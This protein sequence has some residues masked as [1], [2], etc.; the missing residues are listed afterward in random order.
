M[1]KKADNSGAFQALKAALRQKQPHHL[2]IFHGEEDYLRTYYLGALK[3]LLID[4]PAADFNLHRFDARTMDP[5]AFSDAMDAIPVMSEASFIQVDDVDLYQMDAADREQMA[6]LLSDIPDYCYIVFVYDTVAWKPDRRMR[7]FQ[8]VI[9]KNAR[10][11]EFARQPERE[12]MSWVARHF[13]SHG[14]RISPELCRYLINR[15]GGGMTAMAAEIS[16]VAAYCTAQDVS[17]ADVDTVVEPVLDAVVFE[18]TDAIAEGRAALALQTLQTLLKMQQEP[19]PILGAIGSQLR[20]AAAAK[21]LLSVGKGPDAL[22]KLYG[23][24]SYPAQK[25]FGFA[26][27]LPD[28]FFDAALPLCAETDYRIKTS[29]ADPGELLELLVLRLGQEAGHA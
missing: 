28:R 12:L 27:R 19:I 8:A 16:K 17:R 4:G 5:A 29:Y 13:A 7:K 2:Y 25:A 6:A 21:D 1:A 3:K 11:V 18:L 10:I 20:R 15:C 24:S 22:M 14:K 26:R 23:M 9:D